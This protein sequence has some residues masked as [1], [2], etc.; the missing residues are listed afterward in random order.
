MFYELD[1]AG[2]AGGARQQ[3]LEAL[4]SDCQVGALRDRAEE[5]VVGKRG[6]PGSSC[7]RRWAPAYRWVVEG[8]TKKDLARPGAGGRLWCQAAFA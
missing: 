7:F 6:R 3:L 2:V 4:D 8:H 1:L 5:E